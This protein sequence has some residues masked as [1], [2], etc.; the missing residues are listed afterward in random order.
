[1][2]LFSL[3]S[4]SIAIHPSFDEFCLSLDVVSCF[5]EWGFHIPETTNYITTNTLNSKDISTFVSHFNPIDYFNV[6]TT[7]SISSNIISTA[8]PSVSVLADD[9]LR[10]QGNTPGSRIFLTSS[11]NDPPIVIDSGASYS[12]TP[13][14]SDFV[15]GT[16]VSKPSTVDHFS[17][18]TV[19][20]GF[21]Q[22]HWR[23][24]S[25]DGGL[26]HDILPEKTHLIP[27]AQIRLFSPQVYIRQHQQGSVLLDING[28]TLTLPGG[29]FHLTPFNLHNNLPFFNHFQ[30]T[31]SLLF[32]QLT[33]SF[34][35]ILLILIFYLLL[36]LKKQ[37]KHISSSLK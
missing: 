1:M 8:S 15:E 29:R 25:S 31:N 19:Y 12:V 2:S 17:G 21:G 10:V 33:L 24:A 30:S 9:L 18:S 28:C 35:S 20:S 14:M 11:D 5:P 3:S 6:F 16:F 4:P 32:F 37:I 26:P 22:A 27:S 34:P 7:F 13:L 36:C 23:F